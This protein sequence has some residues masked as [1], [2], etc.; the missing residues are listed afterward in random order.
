MHQAI[1]AGHQKTLETAKE[2][3]HAGGNAFDAAIAA[4]LTMFVAE[5]CMAS[6]GGGGFAM[7]F[8]PQQGT[9]FVDFFCQTPI[10]KASAKQSDFYPIQVDFGKD[11]E[12]FFIG[13]GSV[14]TPG[15]MAGLFYLQDKFGSMP[16]QELAAIPMQLAK[17]GVA[18]DKFQSIDFSLLDPILSLHQEGRDIFC[19]EGRMKKEGD[20]V[21]LPQMVN[22]LEFMISE[23]RAGFYH[24]EIGAQIA[25]QQTEHNGLLTRADFENYQ[26]YDTSPLSFDYRSQRVHTAS[27]P[28]IGGVILANYLA[29]VEKDG[30]TK[31]IRRLVQNILDIPYQVKE[32]DNHY[33][34]NYASAWKG[35]ISTKGT[36][37]F[38][39]LDKWGNAIALTT[40]LGEG[41]G[42][43]IKGTQMQLNNMLGE[44]FLLPAGAHSWIAN[45]R[46]N[47]MM[48]PT[49]ITDNKGILQMILGSGGASRIP[50]ALGQVLQYAFEDNLSLDKAIETPR[51]H[52]HDHKLQAELSAALR[53]ESDQNIKFWEEKHMFFGGITAI[54][55]SESKCYAHA[56][57]RR[58]GVAEIF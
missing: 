29:S 39:I 49:L 22:F 7:I 35:S 52:F 27:Y 19:L 50:F 10:Q 32:F 30:K 58:F 28:S 41:N 47:S 38:N 46:L 33:D 54:A 16:F 8:Q 11:T 23:G 48:T 1:S 55:N 12:Q 56:D 9:R 4:H 43:F 40:S 42:T 51:M 36:S 53:G 18:V 2:I 57:S 25:R 6:A 37:H 3:L 17:E 20:I 14:A 31:T 24:G 21:Q 26:V 13:A 34:L 44:L 5:P 15:T 45:Q